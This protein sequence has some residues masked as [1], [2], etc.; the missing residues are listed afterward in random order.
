[1]N[2]SMFIYVY[3]VETGFNIRMRG[4][5][6]DCDEFTSLLNSYKNSIERFIYYKMPNKYDAEDV[7]QEVLIIGYKSFDSLKSK[8]KFKSWISH[9]AND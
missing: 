8:E 7:L 6:V 1:M 2:L 9:L 4:D 5:D 3:K